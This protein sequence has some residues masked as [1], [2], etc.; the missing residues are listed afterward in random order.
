MRPH[1]A[2]WK[3]LCT[4]PPSTLGR[5]ALQSL[6]TQAIG[7][8]K[9]LQHQHISDPAQDGIANYDHASEVQE[10]LRERFLRWKS[11]SS[12]KPDA[13]DT[14]PPRSSSPSSPHRHIPLGGGKTTRP[15]NKPAGYV[16]S[17]R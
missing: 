12:E 13:A 4:T 1:V 8:L 10:R 16:R 11:L 9:I 15:P 6:S 14:C 17:L 3:R 7:N 5:I 2:R